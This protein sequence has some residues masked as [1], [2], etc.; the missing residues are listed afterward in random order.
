MLSPSVA[1]ETQRCVFQGVIAEK[2]FGLLHK[3]TFIEFTQLTCSNMPD[4]GKKQE[5]PL[6]GTVKLK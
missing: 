1:L 6:L 3:L 2:R 5:N 4:G